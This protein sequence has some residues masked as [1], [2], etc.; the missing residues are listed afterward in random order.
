MKTRLQKAVHNY[1]VAESDAKKKFF[2]A[3]ITYYQNKEIKTQQHE[4]T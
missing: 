1:P 3:L 2:A 4:N